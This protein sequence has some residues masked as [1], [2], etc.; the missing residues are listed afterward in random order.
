MFRRNISIFILRSIVFSLLLLAGIPSAQAQSS[1][2]KAEQERM[3]MKQIDDSIPTFRGVEVM[4]DVVGAIQKAVSS[5]GQ[6]EAGV[7]VNLKDKYF[8]TAEIGYGKADETNDVTETSYKTSA[9]YFK[10]GIDFNILKNKHDDYRL[11]VGGRYAYTS[12]KY[13]ITHSP[14]TDPT[15]GG[16]VPFE[17]HDIKANYHWVEAVAGIDAKISGHF[18]LGWTARYRR[19]IHYDSGSMGNVWYVPGFGKQGSSRISGT[20]NIIWEF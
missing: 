13:D 1:R 17:G 15:W 9:P 3:R 12:F 20:F 11:Y 2:K 8:P 5:Y 4:V 6:Y 19:R 10:L 7:R 14:L 18:R 16:E